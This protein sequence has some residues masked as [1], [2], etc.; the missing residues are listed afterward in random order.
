MPYTPSAL[1]GR[2]RDSA[3]FGS[4]GML[5]CALDIV[6]TRHPTKRLPVISLSARCQNQ[7]PSRPLSPV[8]YRNRG[9]VTVLPTAGT[10]VRTVTVRSSELIQQPEPYLCVGSLFETIAIV[11]G[12]CTDERSERNQDTSKPSR[13]TRR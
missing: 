13:L 8:R 7:Q 9:C 3:V 6:S 5:C 1:H 10:E 2:I 12:E 4:M 11:V